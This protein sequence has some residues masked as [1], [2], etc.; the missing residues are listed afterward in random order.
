MKPL[1][2][3]F[4]NQSQEILKLVRDDLKGIKTGRAK[5][6]LV[7]DVKVE[8]YDSAMTLKELASISAPDPQQIIVSPWD[9]GLLAAI[10]KALASSQLNLT[11]VVDGDIVRIK[12]APLTAEAREDLIK[13]VHQKLESM[14]A[15]LRETRGETKSKIEAQKGTSG[16]SEDDIF[17]DLSEL[18]KLTDEYMDKIEEEGKGKEE[19]LKEFNS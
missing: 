15:M 10:E 7:E 9:K 13:L 14:R 6:A 1:L 4:Q 3:E 5:P 11:P 19:E 12:I 18:Q 16:V 17:E 8:A 2:Q